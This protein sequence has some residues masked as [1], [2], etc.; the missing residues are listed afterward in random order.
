M[1]GCVVHIFFDC[2]IRRGVPLFLDPCRSDC[3]ISPTTLTLL[4]R[5]FLF[6]SFFLSSHTQY[7]PP[8]RTSPTLVVRA[9]LQS[10]PYPVQLDPSRRLSVIRPKFARFVPKLKVVNTTDVIV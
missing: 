4:T 1:S 6:F 2:P 9:T 7:I 5:Q 10:L 3:I 8:D